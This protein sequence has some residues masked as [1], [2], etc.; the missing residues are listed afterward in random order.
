M[1]AHAHCS[2]DLST[3][4]QQELPLV[5]CIATALAYYMLTNHRA[6]SAFSVFL[7]LPV[8]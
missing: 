7:K 1:I 2:T 6:A 8:R 4:W 3:A 5:A